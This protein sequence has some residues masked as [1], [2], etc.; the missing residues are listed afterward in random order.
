VQYHP[1]AAPGPMDSGYIFD[2]FIGMIRQNVMPS[3]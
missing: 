3:C 1:E 2:Q